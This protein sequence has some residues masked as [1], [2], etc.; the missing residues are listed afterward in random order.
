MPAPRVSVVV[1][2]INPEYEST[3]FAAGVRG[4][5]FRDYERVIVHDEERRGPA[6]ARNEGIRRAKGEIV[7]FTDDDCRPD[8]DWLERLLAP[9]EDASVVGVEGEIYSDPVIPAG[10]Y[11]PSVKSW[12]H[13]RYKTANVAYRASVLAETGGFDER[14]RY[15]REDTDLGWRALAHGRIAWEPRARVY[16]P[17][18]PIKK[19][20]NP[21]ND[22]LLA[23]KDPDRYVELVAGLWNWRD[24]RAGKTFGHVRALRE[25]ERLFQVRAHVARLYAVGLGIALTRRLYRATKLGVFDRLPARY[26]LSERAGK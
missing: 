15:H 7:A 26:G 18:I 19:S 23:S 4:Q 6:W 14:Y 5:S 3:Q 12:R 17:P 25:G 10:H 22:A 21:E 8:S 13:F 1:P 11:F 24:V 2:T 20:F 16:H 9:F